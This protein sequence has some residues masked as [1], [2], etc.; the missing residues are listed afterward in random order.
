[1]LQPTQSPELNMSNRRFFGSLKCR[2]WRERFGTVDGL[3]E[4][5]QRLFREENSGTLRWVWQNPLKRYNQVLAELEERFRGRADKKE[6]AAASGKLAQIGCT[7][8]D[9][10]PST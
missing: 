4:G 7:V 10:D 9:Q 1:M 6:K 2:V 8:V 3:F 5:V